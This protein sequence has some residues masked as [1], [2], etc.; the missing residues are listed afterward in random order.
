MSTL[1]LGLGNTLRGDD[2]I[3]VRAVEALAREPWGGVEVTFLATPQLL[4]EHVEL[5]HS[6]DRVVFVDAAV[7]VPPAV[8]TASDVAP[9]DGAAVTFHDLTPGVLLALC[10]SMFGRAPT[11]TLVRIGVESTEA[12]TEL[13]PALE[14]RF[15]DYCGVI[16]AAIWSSGACVSG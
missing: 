7:D 11:A 1:V 4:I 12:S 2:G 15:E 9:L 13:T 5:L 14:A 10:R 16:R 3:G 8:I 6:A